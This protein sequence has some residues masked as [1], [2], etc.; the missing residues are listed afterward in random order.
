MKTPSALRLALACAGILCAARASAED[1]LA[2]NRLDAWQLITSPAAPIGEVCHFVGDGVLAVAGKPLGYL[3]THKVYSSYR[4]HVE[5]RWTQGPGNS[6]VLVHIASGPRD[7]V[8]PVC[9]QVQTKVGRV[10]DLLPMAGATFET[11]LS[12]APG[13]KTPQRDRIAP[14]SEKPVGEWNSC[15]VEVDGGH[16]R[17]WV[18]DVLQND[19]RGCSVTAGTV[20]MQLEGA[21][22]EMR[23][24]T[25]EPLTP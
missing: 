15:T 21:P 5:W 7:R 18:N 11:P 10:G 23:H 12:T 20:G 9:F 19:V 16:I 6:G 25:I 24:F 14:D 2:G 13:A 17:A 1:L 22:Y 8:W 4:L 3:A